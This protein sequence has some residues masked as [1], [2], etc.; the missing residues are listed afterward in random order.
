MLS[1]RNGSR[2]ESELHDMH[3]TCGTAPN[4]SSRDITRQRNTQ[5]S[6]KRLFILGKGK[7][8]RSIMLF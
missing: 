2:E 3:L 1:D 7:S 5:A 8:H 6:S 4:P